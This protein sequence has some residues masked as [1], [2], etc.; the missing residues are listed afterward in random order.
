MKNSIQSIEMK[1]SE[2]KIVE[3]STCYAPP[4]M[5][6]VAMAARGIIMLNGS[7]STINPA[8]EEGDDIFGE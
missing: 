7:G 8:G 4:A 1:K 5:R 6:F 3:E 2:K